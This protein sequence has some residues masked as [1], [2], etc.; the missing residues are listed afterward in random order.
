MLYNVTTMAS[1]WHTVATKDVRLLKRQLDQ[2]FAL[3]KEYVFLNYLRCH[4]DIGWGLDYD[5]LKNFGMEEVA[6]K[7]YLNDYLTGKWAGSDARGELYNDDPRLGDARLCG[8]TASLSGLEAALYEKDEEKAK[9]A[10]KCI[11]MLHAYL[12]SQ[13]GIPMLYS[14]DE[15]GQLND[16]TYK[17]DPD[18]QADSRYLHRGNFPWESV[19]EE[20]SQ[21]IF[22][23]LRK[24][25]QIRAEKEIFSME[26]RT[27][28]FETGSD[29]VL[30]ICRELDGRRL[31]AYYNFS[32][33]PVKTGGNILDDGKDY[34]DL[35]TERKLSGEAGEIEGYG[36]L[37]L[38]GES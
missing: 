13:S 4:D 21:E 22:Q 2:V 5:W 25:E 3:P 8:T 19:K 34:K 36:Y 12:L 35:V 20:I 17:E 30:G 32:G 16:Y 38:Y 11:V 9:K 28:T 33:M 24:L 15:I 18:K 10:V 7:K 31:V 23:T 37:W 1:T 26:A 27:Y 29:Q 6:H 14:G